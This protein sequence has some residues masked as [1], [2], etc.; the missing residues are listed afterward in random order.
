MPKA[1]LSVH[2]KTGIVEFAK[3]L[4]EIALHT[5][6]RDHR[7]RIHAKTLLGPLQSLA[8]LDQAGCAIGHALFV[9]QG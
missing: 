6:D 1:I 9:H 3:G 2:D 5:P 7:G 4:A 8:V